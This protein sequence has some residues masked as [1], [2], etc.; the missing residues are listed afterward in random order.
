MEVDLVT[1]DDG[2][3]PVLRELGPAKVPAVGLGCMGMSEFYGEVDDAA[4][5]E[6][7]TASFDVGYRHCDTADMYGRGHNEELVGRFLHQMRSHRDELVIATKFGIRRDQEDKSHFA[8]DG[9]PA[10]VREACEHSLSRLGTDV[11][12]LALQRSV[13][14][15][16]G[17][18]T[19]RVEC[20]PRG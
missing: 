19:A 17:R 20:L 12:D 13:L 16:L 11:I 2:V 10:Y 7:L 5:L 15:S 6:V 14:Q 3:P 9:S 4:S 18:L 8:V 1:Q